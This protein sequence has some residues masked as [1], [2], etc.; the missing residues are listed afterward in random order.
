MAI[1]AP[2][3]R[4]D[5][6]VRALKG[7]NVLGQGCPMELFAR[8]EIFLSVMCNAVVTSRVWLLSAWHVAV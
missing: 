1:G 6:A 3:S 4:L 5:K 2:F 8:M 7:K